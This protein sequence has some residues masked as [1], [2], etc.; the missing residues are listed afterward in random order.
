M[1]FGPVSRTV[2][3]LITKSLLR[4]AGLLGKGRAEILEVSDAG[5]VMLSQDPIRV[6]VDTL[7]Q[8]SD[9]EKIMLVQTLEQI[10]VALK[11]APDLYAD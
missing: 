4:R 7:D 5:R 2:R 1:A 3:T 11:S 10:L 9:D 8:L 6:V